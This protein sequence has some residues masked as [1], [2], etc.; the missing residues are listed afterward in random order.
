[1]KEYPSAD[2]RNLALVGHAGAGKTMLAEAILAAGGVINRLGSIEN[3]STVSDFQS[4]EHERQISIGASLLHTD[5][6]N[7]K[8]N[9]LDTPGYLDFL[10]EAKAALSICDCAV[11]VV[12][13]V[14]GVEVGTSQVVEWANDK[15]LAK[16]VVLN[17]MDKEHVNFDT[18]LAGI[19][20]S[21]GTAVTP[22]TVPVNA[23]PGFNQ[24]LDVL[25][26]EVVT[27]E[28]DGMGK[29]T[30]AAAEGDLAEQAESMH[31]ELIEAVAASDDALMEKFFEEGSLSDEELRSGLGAALLSGELI[32]L[33][34]TATTSNVGVS[35]L[36][37]F[38]AKFGIAPTDRGPVPAKA[39]DD[40][41][42]EVAIDGTEPVLQIFKTISDRHVGNLS[43]FKLL[44][45]SLTAGSDLKN[46]TQN[47]SE[48]VGQIFVLNGKENETADKLNAGD[49]GALVK[50]KQTH[51]SDTLCSAKAAVQLPPI[52]F[53]KPNIHEALRSKSKG[54][55][56]KIA[57]GLAALHEE[58][59]TFV[60]RVDGELHQT[61]ISGMG[62]LH[63]RV[64]SDK[65]KERY[66]V[67]IELFEP[68]VP[69]RETIKGAGES[70]Y[71]HKKQS[72]GAGQFAE[73][74]MRIEPKDRD[75]GLEFVDSLVGMNVDRVFVPSVEKGVNAAATEGVIAGYRVVDLK[76]DF[77]DGKMHPVDSK[78][79]AFQI[80][81][82]GA[83]K[84]AVNAAKPTLLEPIYSI[85]V[86][87]PDDFTGAVSG[88]LSSRRGR[89]QGM[90]ANGG[91]QIVKAHVP[92]KE[93]YRYSTTLRSLTEGR[94]I[95]TEE[96]SHY[97]EMP[98]DM[99]KKVVTESQKEK[100]EE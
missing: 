22:L 79:V 72:G 84:E 2:I 95:H 70:K 17:G 6:Q 52:D 8:L 50:L 73:V 11:V 28:I 80:A 53:P 55:E 97:E 46:T 62:E 45:G 77:Y 20:D 38:A 99:Q 7:K 27:Y 42:T 78:D 49:L 19:R 96:F 23:G 56:D 33:F 69:Y 86:K 15:G 14:E 58:D 82:K 18:A 16:F 90:D 85:E 3:G 88:D 89:L 40:S 9:V 100:E 75:S 35:R 59:P 26:K 57:Q 93:L 63:L 98:G 13:A 31:A 87:I 10:A 41:D 54:D 43:F 5:W 21:L 74:W 94:G 60:Y 51:T 30:A 12:N 47:G 64:V 32:P 76:V 83:F 81:G 39:A 37:D 24:V 65:L 25:T 61:V 48:R 36:M 67:E 66:N 44:S 68:K 91:F 1:M 34:T 4:A 29:C 92:Q 71:R